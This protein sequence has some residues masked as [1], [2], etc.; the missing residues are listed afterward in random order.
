MNT[1]PT[2]KKVIWTFVFALL[3]NVA[4]PLINWLI[5]TITWPLIQKYLETNQ[6]QGLFGPATISTLLNY[7]ISPTNIIL[8]VIELIIIYFIWSL[9]Q[10]KRQP[11]M[12]VRK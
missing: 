2:K 11:K 6:V 5:T 9:F 12:P 7:L 4:V 10:R 1:R 8:F 3:I